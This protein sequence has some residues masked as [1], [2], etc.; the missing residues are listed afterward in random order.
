MTILENLY[1]SVSKPVPWNFWQVK[2]SRTL[3]DL[4]PS[5]PRKSIQ[6]DLH[7]ALADS[8]FQAKAVQIAFNL[9]NIKKD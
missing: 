8:Y 2:D 1:R 3:F 4:C 7:N 6:S 9:L 5:D